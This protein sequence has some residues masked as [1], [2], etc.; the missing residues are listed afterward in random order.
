MCYTTTRSSWISVLILCSLYCVESNDLACRE[1][2]FE[3]VNKGK[4]SYLVKTNSCR[5]VFNLSQFL[6]VSFCVLSRLRI[7][8]LTA[9]VS[10]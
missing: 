6:N 2:I 8:F 9:S 5:F 1:G 10:V 4:Y 7:S 3:T